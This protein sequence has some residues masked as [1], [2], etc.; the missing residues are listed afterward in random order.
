MDFNFYVCKIMATTNRCPNCGSVKVSKHKEVGCFWIVFF[1]ISI[2]IGLI[3]Y[4]FLPINYKCRECGT[5]WK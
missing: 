5:K 4:P 1:F 2:G 3:M